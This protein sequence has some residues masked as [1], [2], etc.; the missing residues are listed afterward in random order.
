LAAK[1]VTLSRI[2]RSQENR[3]R[4]LKGK[5]QIEEMTRSLDQRRTRQTVRAAAVKEQKQQLEKR[6]AEVDCLVQAVESTRA[7]ARNIDEQVDELEGKL[8][9]TVFEICRATRELSTIDGCVFV[10]E[11]LATD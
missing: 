2:K 5:E 11:I 4:E 10:R 1:I 7:S 9:R 8:D 6:Q 3:R